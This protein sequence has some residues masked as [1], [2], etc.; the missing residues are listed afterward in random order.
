MT[1]GRYL[2]PNGMVYT[3]YNGSP[4]CQKDTKS[5]KMWQNHFSVIF[6]VP[7]DHRIHGLR[8]NLQPEPTKMTCSG[9]WIYV[10]YRPK[11]EKSSKSLFHRF[12][13]FWD[14]Y[15]RAISAKTP[16]WFT[17]LVFWNTDVA[18]YNGS[19][20]CQI[21]SKCCYFTPK[22]HDLDSNIVP[23][24][25][26]IA[27]EH[28][29]W[30]KITPKMT[31]FGAK[32]TPN[33]SKWTHLEINMVQISSNDVIWSQ[34]HSILVYFELNIIQNHSKYVQISPNDMILVIWHGWE[35]WCG[36]YESCDGTVC[37]QTTVYFFLYLL[38]LVSLRHCL[39]I[40][41][42]VTPGRVSISVLCSTLTVFVHG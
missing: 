37:A 10:K 11:H 29:F 14:P 12:L 8:P 7:G 22:W 33:Q 41:S 15:E 35:H 18:R 9:P 2:S 27:P 28:G 38:L 20:L 19:P 42:D 23:N 36:P 6:G 34:N 13:M 16:L 3:I 24:S 26:Q 1:F 4:L 30:S 39:F 21:S 5:M 40:K 25:S 31:W 32:M 17:I